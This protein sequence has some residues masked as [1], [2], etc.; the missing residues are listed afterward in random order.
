[1]LLS[2]FKLFRVK[3]SLKLFLSDVA[4]KPLVFDLIRL[5]VHNFF[6]VKSISGNPL[7]SLSQL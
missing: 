5:Q 1:M 7:Q 3:F 4:R 6:D 2:N